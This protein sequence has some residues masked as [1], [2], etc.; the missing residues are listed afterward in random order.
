M[1]MVVLLMS[2]T[3]PFPCGEQSLFPQRVAGVVSHQVYVLLQMLS[4]LYCLSVFHV[5]D[6]DRCMP[7]PTCRVVFADSV[8]CRCWFI[9]GVCPTPHA[10]QYF[11]PQRVAVVG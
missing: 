2:Q 3:C 11:L 4:S 6:C 10:E 5:F 9:S 7:H 1:D 8:C